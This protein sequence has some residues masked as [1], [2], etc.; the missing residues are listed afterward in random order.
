MRAPSVGAGTGHRLA[1]GRTL[2]RR[3]RLDRYLRPFAAA[4]GGY[5]PSSLEGANGETGGANGA[6]GAADAPHAGATA[7]VGMF[8]GQRVPNAAQPEASEAGG[9]MDRGVRPG[10]S[11][12]AF[13]APHGRAAPTKHGSAASGGRG[14]GCGLCSAHALECAEFTNWPVEH[15]CCLGSGEEAASPQHP[16]AGSHVQ[17]RG[18]G[19]DVGS[20]PGPTAAG[21]PTPLR[22]LRGERPRRWA[23][24]ASSRRRRGGSLGAAPPGWRR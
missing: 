18:V 21:A 3:C 9:R 12:T 7:I 1:S 5:G 19:G 10:W 23:P 22:R 6:D 20:Q 24:W 11:L 15:A 13:A 16:P 4:L 2:G 14:M 8:R 17:G